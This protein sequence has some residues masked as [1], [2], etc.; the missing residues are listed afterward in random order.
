VEVSGTLHFG[1]QDQ[2]K[3]VPRFFDDLDDVPI[4]VR[5][6]QGVDAVEGRTVMPVELFERPD[7][8]HAG[9]GFRARGDRI[10][11]VEKEKV[12]SGE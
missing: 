12:R 8:V 2:V 3:P 9:A 4:E 6:V 1:D 5:G 7:D 11:E 10:F